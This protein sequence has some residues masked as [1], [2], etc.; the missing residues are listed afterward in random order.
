MSAIIK[1][2]LTFTTFYRSFVAAYTQKKDIATLI[3]MAKNQS[4]DALIMLYDSEALKAISWSIKTDKA[5]ICDRFVS[6]NVEKKLLRL[7]E[8]GEISDYHW[9]AW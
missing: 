9:P 7:S 1:K 8:L 5:L 4:L 6:S 3:S 2:R